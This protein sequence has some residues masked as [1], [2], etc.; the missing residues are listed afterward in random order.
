MNFLSQQALS[1]VRIL[2][3]FYYY[4]QTKKTSLVPV[5]KDITPIGAPD[6]EDPSR[7]TPQDLEKL[8]YSKE[9]HELLNY[10][11]IREIIKKIDCSKTPE[12]D[13]NFIRSEDS[14]FDDFTKKLVEIT[15]KE[16]LD[17]MKKKGT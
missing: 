4:L 1:K 5:R 8:A 15:Y 3:V 11:Q 17:A 12:K 9:I 7:L 10:P 13:L 14:V 6:E 2:Q 16:K